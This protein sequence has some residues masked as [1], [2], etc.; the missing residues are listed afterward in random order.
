MNGFLFD[1][2]LPTKIRFEISLPII[3]VNTLGKGLTD[4]KLWEYAKQ[5]NLVIIS[6]D[7]D[8]SNRMIV[9]KPPPR[10]IH[11]RLGNMKKD[12]FHDFLAKIWPKVE[13]LIK[14]NRLV[15]VYTNRIEIIE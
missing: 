6:K 14:D 7:A 10:V 4:T 3:H 2:N 11:L 5:N 8:F 12:E 9:S 1:E 15:N 13:Q